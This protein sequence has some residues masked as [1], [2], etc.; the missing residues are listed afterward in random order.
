MMSFKKIFYRQEF[1]LE[2][3]WFRRMLEDL[4]DLRY[5][6]KELSSVTNKA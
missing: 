1:A 3:L 6:T 2:D 5:L 4:G